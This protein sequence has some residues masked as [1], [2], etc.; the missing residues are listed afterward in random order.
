M[1]EV[2]SKIGPDF[3]RETVKELLAQHK[4]PC[5]S[6]YFPLDQK[7]T[8]A[9]VNATHLKTLLQQATD[10]LRALSVGDDE[11]DALL[12]PAY[13]L[14]NDEKF[15]AIK[16]EGLALFIAPNFMHWI[17]D[18]SQVIE[19]SEAVFV[20]DHF[21]VK[22]LLPLL[23]GD[24]QFYVLTLAQEHVGLLVGTRDKIASVE[25]PNLPQSLVEALGEEVPPTQIQGRVQNVEGGQQTAVFGGYDPGD[26][27]KERVHR[28]LVEVNKAVQKYLSGQTVPLI[29]AGLEYLHP[30]YRDINTYP[31]LVEQGIHENAITLQVPELHKL[32]WQIVEPRFTADRQRDLDRFHQRSGNQVGSSNNLAEILRAAH[33]ARIDTLFIREGQEQFGYYDAR[34]D[35]LEVYKDARPDAVDLYDEAATHTILNGGRVYIL[36]PEE[37]PMPNTNITNITA[38]LRY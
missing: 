11:I 9:P 34:N 25:V 28:F 6:I 17:P 12:E 35:R 2:S 31:H 37:M 3:S 32:A 7:G 33:F 36:K 30:M 20:G 8:L 29:V 24:G 15:W 19:F 27:G 26:Y 10:N 14:V 23:T 1:Q 4:G 5:V 13:G 22:L 18:N 38:I 21:H 16:A